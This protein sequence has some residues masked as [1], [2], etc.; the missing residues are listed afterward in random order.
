MEENQCRLISHSSLNL[1]LIHVSPITVLLADFR[2][3]LNDFH[4]SLSIDGTSLFILA[5]QETL[6]V[7]VWLRVVGFVMLKNT[8]LI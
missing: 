4:C 2:P 8:V 1:F 7:G 5:A 3:G 6:C